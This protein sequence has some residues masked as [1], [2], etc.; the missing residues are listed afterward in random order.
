MDVS[1]I[2]VNWNSAVLLRR[3]LETI[4]SEPGQIQLE[5]IV[6]DNASFDGVRELVESE[7]PA[8]HFVQSITNLGFAAANNAAFGYS[9]GRN[10]LFLN[11]DTEIVG[12]ALEAM[13]C[14]LDSSPTF[15]VV[16]GKL[17]N[18]DSS[19]QTS[20]IQSFPTVWNQLLDT[21]LLRSLFPHAKIWGTGPLWSDSA[22]PMEVDVVSGACLMI[23]RTVFEQIGRFSTNYFMYAEDA[24]LCYK[25]KQAGWK[26]EYLGRIQVIHHGG[27]SSGM[28]ERR[29]STVMM[30]QSLYEFLRLTQGRTHAE[31]Y[32][33]TMALSASIRIFLLGAA[34]FFTV[35]LFRPESSRNAVRKWRNVLRWA[36]GLESGATQP[37]SRYSHSVTR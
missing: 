33:I 7:F 34:L 11:P 30:K 14:V 21:E 28:R 4:Y 26:I 8:V 1:V 32:R 20:C 37:L 6:I 18:S 10:I 2:I 17:L 25:V 24:D 36:L 13:A 35:G 29:F 12:R 16:G 31:L 27:C 19:V 15:G 23:K 5:V 22:R 3:C 9:K